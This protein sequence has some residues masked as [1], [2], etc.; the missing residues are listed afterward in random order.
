MNNRKKLP[1]GVKNFEK[2]IKENFYYVD[3]TT[4]IVA[5]LK[6]WAKVN[7]FTRPR[8][9][10]KSLNMNMLQLFFEIGRDKS[11]FEGLKISEEKELC[12]KYMGKFPVISISLKGIEG[13][14]FQ[15]AR[16]AMQYVIG[17]EIRRFSFLTESEKLDAG[18]RKMY[19][20][21]VRIDKGRFPA[22]EEMLPVSLL[23]KHYG[24]EVIILID[25]YDVPLDKDFQYGY[26]DEM[27]MLIRGLFGNALKTNSNLFFAVLIGCLRVSKES[28][29]TGLNNF[30]IYSITNVEFD[31]YFGFTDTEVKEMLSYYGIKECYDTVKEW[32][33]GYQFGETDVYCPWD[34]INYCKNR[35]ADINALPEDY[36][37]NTSG[38]VMVR[39]FID[40]E[41]YR[42]KNEIEQLIAGESIIKEIRQDLTYNELDSSI[43]NLWS[44]LFTTGYL[45][46]DTVIS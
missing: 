16:E 15:T 41:D 1:V 32:Y 34:V 38:N 29:F 39:R 25:E 7:V 12:D 40:K 5:L 42:T 36:W 6:S 35:C 3:K 23:A 37:S 43:E 10:G 11:V 9:F 28:I 4:I 46:L 30:N 27:V 26:Y 33:D 19:D 20:S 24:K 8:R 13:Q 21:M 14:N 44:V 2:L 22:E 18:E 45:N 17:S 31:E